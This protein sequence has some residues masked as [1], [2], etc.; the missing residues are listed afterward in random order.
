MYNRERRNKDFRQLNKIAIPL[1]VQNVA[2]MMI[3]MVDEV[4]VGHISS[5]AYVGVG[6]SVSLLNFLAGV[7]SYF[8][9]AFNIS[10]ARKMGEKDENE[11]RILLTSSLLIDVAV[12]TLF[13]IFMFVFSKLIFCYAYGLSGVALEATVKYARITCPCL[14]AQMCIF[15]MNSYFKI[16][17]KTNK[18]MAVSIACSLLNVGLDY[19]LIF[20]KAGLPELGVVGAGISTLISVFVNACVLI[21]LARRDINFIFADRGQYVI[22]AKRMIKDSIPLIGEELLEGSVFVVGINMIV[23]NIGVIQA[24]GYILTNN[25][26]DIVMIS[27]YMYGNAELTL[28]SERFGEN[29]PEEIMPLARL[30]VLVSMA[31]YFVLGTI[32]IIFR[33]Q[34]PKIITDDV[35]L[36]T[37]ASMIILPMLVANVFN[38]IQTIYKY[39]LQACDDGKYVLYVT[40][41]VNL[42]VFVLMILLQS[43]LEVF[44]VFVC[45]LL[46]YGVIALI[47]GKRLRKKSSLVQ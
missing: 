20:G 12:G 21:Y 5:E 37:F 13:A 43:V 19:L 6:L 15:T 31:F 4:F 1:I 25:L 22:K 46:N 30:G 8:A 24:G 17:K 38:P 42:V 40:A 41:A 14:L 34:I 2:C 18:L 10:G 16:F 29:K 44:A 27:M 32:L 7:F 28:T 39:V 26:L 33:A 45:L 3:G 35:S 9:I 11:F 36:M 23:S 47:Y